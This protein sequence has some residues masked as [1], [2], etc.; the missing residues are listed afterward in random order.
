MQ[1]TLVITRFTLQEAISRRLILA[2]LVL[3]LLF[4]GLF[5]FGFS[6][7]Y[8]RVVDPL[9]AGAVV[10]SAADLWICRGRRPGCP[11]ARKLLV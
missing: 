11:T 2:G 6:F 4:L 1:S 8:G 3:S 5:A 10:M 9:V 7:V